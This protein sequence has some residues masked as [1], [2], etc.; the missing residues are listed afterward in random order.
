[1]KNGQAV[2]SDYQPFDQRQFKTDVKNIIAEF[3]ILP[4]HEIEKPRV[5]LVGEILVKFLPDANN[6]AVEIVEKEGGEAVMPGLT[7]FLSYC[8]FNGAYKARHL[9]EGSVWKNKLAIAYLQFSR[10]TITKYLK[11]SKRF[12]PAAPI[13]KVAKMAARI[14]S[15]G[16]QAGEGWLLTGEMAELHHQGINNIIC[17]QPFA[18]LPNH[19]TG[20]GTLR[21]FR[22]QFPQ[23]NIVAVDY[24]PGASES[25]QLN[26]IKLMM[27][28]AFKQMEE[29]A[30]GEARPP[31]STRKPK[32]IRGKLPETA[33]TNDPILKPWL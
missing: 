15:L 21:E 32:Q 25:N 20:R 24:D 6:Q 19:I 17:M 18:C 27:S 2:Q 11:R 28:V 31:I 9:K 29:G 14:V 30:N 23:S 10:R 16:N 7:D 26:R 13:G 4:L 1:M 8:A 3:D 33:Q 12:E 22:R 5:G